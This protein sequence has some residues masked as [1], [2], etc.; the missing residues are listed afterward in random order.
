ME[1]WYWIEGS[2]NIADWITRGKEPKEL[3]SESLWQNGPDFMKHPIDS[4]PVRNAVCTGI[5]PKEKKIGAVYGVQT[6]CSEINIHRYS[7]YRKLIQVTVRFKF[8]RTCRVLHLKI[9][10]SFLL[11]K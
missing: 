4:W 11:L 3:G 1:S 7:K 9:S 10:S 5:L 8:F 2:V 6:I